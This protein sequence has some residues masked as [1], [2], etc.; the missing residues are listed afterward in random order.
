AEAGGGGGRGGGGSGRRRPG[1]RWP[2]GYRCCGP[3][4]A[5]R[6]H[7][8]EQG[9][10]V[11]AGCHSFAQKE[12]AVT[13]SA[14]VQGQDLLQM[15]SRRDWLTRTGAGFAGLA[16]G[17]LLAE[18]RAAA[19]PSTPTSGAHYPPKARAV[20]QLFQHGGPSH[21]DLF[22]PKP[23]L[24]KRN[25]QPMPKYFTDLVKISAHGNLLGTPF[26]FRPS[27][28]GGVE[29]SEIVPHTATCADDIAVIRSMYT[30]H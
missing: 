1:R 2:R 21:V 26:K 6:A 10:E 14:S 17:A 23:E 16:L 25:G 28:K 5:Q 12:P 15:L 9:R 27:G 24:N 22:D 7:L 11:T 20:L 3:P 30:E 18:E 19:A 13:G 8:L 29:Y 4:D